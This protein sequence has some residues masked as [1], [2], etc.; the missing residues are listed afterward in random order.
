MKQFWT[1]L[2]REY[3]EHRTSFLGIPLLIGFLLFFVALC[4]A[5]A[6]VFGFNMGH[7]SANIHVD[8]PVGLVPLVFYALGVPYVL[9]L[10]VMMGTYFLGTLFDDRRDKSILFWQSMP[11]SQWTHISAKLFAGLVMAPFI[12]FICLL[13]TQVAFL[14]LGTALFAYLHIEYWPVFWRPLPMLWTWFSQLIGLF[15]Q[16]IWMFPLAAW[17][18]FCSA[19]SRRAPL[20]R[21]VLP[22]VILLAIEGFFL[23]QPYLWHFI[24][25]CMFHIVGVWVAIMLLIG[26]FLSGGDLPVEQVLLFRFYDSMLFLALGV[27]VIFS[28][29]AGLV[30]RQCYDH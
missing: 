24:Q 13:V 15:G 21:V 2:R 29:L 23:P 30:R 10:W 8:Q 28:V 5:L 26:G 17:F 25:T 9:V 7:F 14:L 22:L 4:A 6:F 1:L 11:I 19:V 20:I 3:W 18:M 27:G 12:T 16:S